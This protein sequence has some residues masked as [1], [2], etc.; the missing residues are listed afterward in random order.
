MN[1]K[2]HFPGSGPGYHKYLYKNK[3]NSYNSL[4]NKLNSRSY[5]TFENYSEL[6]QRHG[7]RS[8]FLLQEGKEE[9]LQHTAA[10]VNK[11]INS[12]FT[13]DEKFNKLSELNPLLNFIT[14]KYEWDESPHDIIKQ[15]LRYKL[16]KFPT[17]YSTTRQDEFGNVYQ[18]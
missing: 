14:N 7:P 3:L 11:I 12:N 18:P 6:Y 10:C 15:H 5:Y 8:S 2:S 13:N 1:S 17:I 16:N 4:F 9:I